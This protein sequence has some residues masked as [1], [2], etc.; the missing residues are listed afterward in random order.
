ME[1]VVDSD[2]MHRWARR[3]LILILLAATFW[4]TAA[5]LRSYDVWWLIALGLL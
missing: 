3:G 4:V 1:P 5:P 2:L